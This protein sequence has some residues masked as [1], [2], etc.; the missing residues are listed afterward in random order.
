MLLCKQL[1]KST[2]MP[3][4]SFLLKEQE[5]KHDWQT[6]IQCGRSSYIYCIPIL[7][8]STVGSVHFIFPWSK[9]FKTTRTS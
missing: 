7:D 3:Y 1:L 4:A 9:K 5:T 8:I 2:L 6:K